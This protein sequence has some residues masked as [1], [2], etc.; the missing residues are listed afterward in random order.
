MITLYHFSDV[1]GVDPSPFCLKVETYFRLAKIPFEKSVSFTAF[2][3]APRKKLPYI[4]DDNKTIADSELI[5]DYVN[6]KYHVSLDDWLSPEQRA[7]S[8]TLRRMIEEGTYWVAVFE[9]WMDPKVWV[10]YKPVVLGAIPAPMRN[11]AGV[12]LRRDYKRR[13]YGQG[14]SRYSP[15]EIKRIGER[16]V[17]AVATLLAEKSYLF[18]DKPSSVDAVVF[19]LLGNVYYAPLETEMKRTISSYPNLTAYLD[20]LHKLV[21][22]PRT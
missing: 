10:T 11:A 22:V 1:W 19:G 9:R 4:V 15:A 20:R 5:I 16:D 13:L 8:H 21:A 18:G 7:V 2:L 14:V 6:N 3:K 12:V 17:G